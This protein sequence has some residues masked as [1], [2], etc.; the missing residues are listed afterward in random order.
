MK[1]AL[2]AVVAKIGFVADF[3]GALGIDYPA[4]GLKNSSFRHIRTCHHGGRVY[5]DVAFN[6][7]VWP[8]CK[9]KDNN[10]GESVVCIVKRIAGDVPGGKDFEYSSRYRQERLSCGI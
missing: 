5:H 6:W 9:I 3:M 7:N 10:D 1:T 2:L 8:H 4:I